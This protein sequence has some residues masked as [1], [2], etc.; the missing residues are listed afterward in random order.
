MFTY[1]VARVKRVKV[2]AGAAGASAELV[3]VEVAVAALGVAA[4]GVVERPVALGD[5]GPGGAG[6]GRRC[7]RVRRE[8]EPPHV[9][10]DLGVLGGKVLLAV[11]GP[12]E[13]VDVA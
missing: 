6:V 12:H 1:S 9:V 5:H 3:E 11:V 10:V 2:D 13:P 8:V 7:A 4:A